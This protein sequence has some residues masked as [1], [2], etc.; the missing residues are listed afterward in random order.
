MQSCYKCLADKFLSCMK[1]K[2][3]LCK[4]N[5]MTYSM[6]KSCKTLFDFLR[7]VLEIGGG[8]YACPYLPSLLCFVV[9]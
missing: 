9:F 2:L 6:K 3:V 1:Y 4:I 5:A 7:A 8:G